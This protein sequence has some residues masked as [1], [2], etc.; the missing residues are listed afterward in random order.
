MLHHK[1]EDTGHISVS[2]FIA[3]NGDDTDTAIC[4]GFKL[5]ES[6]FLRFVNEHGH[7]TYELSGMEVISGAATMEQL[8]LNDDQWKDEP[9]RLFRVAVN[10]AIDIVTNLKMRR[11]YPSHYGHDKEMKRSY[12]DM[13]GKKNRTLFKQILGWKLWSVSDLDSSGKETSDT[14]PD[15]NMLVITDIPAESQNINLLKES[16]NPEYDKETRKDVI[17]S[18]IQHGSLKY[19]W[20]TLN[21]KCDGLKEVA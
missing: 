21:R 16:V 6:Y 4:E 17:D 20:Q 14:E 3:M 9:F 2:P 18:I 8:R 1:N 5:V 12:K 15:H 13:V 10:E 19:D 11:P 7:R